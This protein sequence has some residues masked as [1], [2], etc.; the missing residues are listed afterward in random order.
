MRTFARSQARAHHEVQCFFATTGDVRIATS[1]GVTPGAYSS[2]RKKIL[3]IDSVQR[4]L[5][6]TVQGCD[7]QKADA[8]SICRNQV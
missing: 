8:K 4:A 6:A 3:G 7:D 1:F 2:L 5:L